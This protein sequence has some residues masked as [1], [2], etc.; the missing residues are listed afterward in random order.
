MFHEL[1]SLVTEGFLPESAEVDFMGTTEILRVIN[2]QDRRVA[3]AVAECI[4]EIARVVDAVTESFRRGAR[5]LYVGAGT[6]GRLGIL[7]AAECPPTFGT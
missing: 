1:A 5:L 2:E 7:D 6:S 3:P 4:G